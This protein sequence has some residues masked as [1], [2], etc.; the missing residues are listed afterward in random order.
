[1]S[2]QDNAPPVTEEPAMI[3]VEPRDPDP[4]NTQSMFRGSAPTE[5]AG[6]RRSSRGERRG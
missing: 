3:P 6:D 4:D 1:M 2:E 5:S